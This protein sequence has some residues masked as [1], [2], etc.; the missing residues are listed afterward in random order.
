MTPQQ[1]QALIDATPWSNGRGLVTGDAMRQLLTDIVSLLGGVGN[2]ATLHRTLQ[3]AFASQTPTLS[4]QDFLTNYVTES[5]NSDGTYAAVYLDPAPAIGAQ[6]YNLL[7]AFLVAKGYSSD[8]AN[9][10]L[11]NIWNASQPVQPPYG[12]PVALS[13]SDLPTT[14]PTGSGVLWNNGGVVSIS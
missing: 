6:F 13:P 11:T 1:V 14:L 9:T 8:T 3:S 5:G 12:S 2:L 7:M 4:F 10:L